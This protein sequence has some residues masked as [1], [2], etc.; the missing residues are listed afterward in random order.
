MK[1]NLTIKS[2]KKSSEDRFALQ[3]LLRSFIMQQKSKMQNKDFK[4]LDQQFEVTVEHTGSSLTAS[5][6]EGAN[7][8]SSSLPA[9][10]T[11]TSTLQPA[12][13]PQPVIPQPPQRFRCLQD[14]TLCIFIMISNQAQLSLSKQIN[15]Q[16]KSEEES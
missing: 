16:F 7:Q 10:S 13:I 11:V 6:A 1:Q 14:F 4:P 8:Q 2:L 3:E 12:I 9:S 5:P 15:N